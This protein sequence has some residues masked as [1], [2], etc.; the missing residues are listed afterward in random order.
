MSYHQFTIAHLLINHESQTGSQNSSTHLHLAIIEGDADAV[1]FLLDV[2]LAEARKLVASSSSAA[3]ASA[4]LNAVLTC[5]S[6]DEIRLRIIS[7]L[8]RAGLATESFSPA[9]DANISEDIRQLLLQ[10]TSDFVTSSTHSVFEAIACGS[11]NVLEQ[12]LACGLDMSSCLAS[13]GSTLIHA[14]VAKG[15]VDML[16]LVLS[17][18]CCSGGIINTKSSSGLTALHIAA[19]LDRSSCISPLLAHSAD[20]NVA[21]DAACDNN[22][23][24]LFAAAHNSHRAFTSLLASGA[25]VFAVN[26]LGLNVLHVA[27]A[28][29]N[30]FTIQSMLSHLSSVETQGAR[31]QSFV[32]AVSLYGDTP[33]HLCVLSSGIQPLKALKCC[34]LLL[35]VCPCSRMYIIH[36]LLLLG[37]CITKN[38]Q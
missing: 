21:A 37:R 35:Q 14:C 29:G 26:R 8:R 18:P 22:T 2:P 13:D 27:A 32:A 33:L 11:R 23:P 7:T 30:T 3:S 15:A 12:W 20:L 4:I 10:P 31:M 17:S 25:D 28:V 24:L 1:D 36:G 38:P 16:E 6:S 5:K 19:K 34:F 9:T